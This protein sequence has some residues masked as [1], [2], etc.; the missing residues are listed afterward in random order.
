MLNALP[1]MSGD[2]LS[3]LIPPLIKEAGRDPMTGDVMTYNLK[4]KK[5]RVTKGKQK[6][7]MVF[8]L[9]KN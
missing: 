5:G 1:R 4:T 7:M 9:G 6:Q 3:E 8:I 2:T